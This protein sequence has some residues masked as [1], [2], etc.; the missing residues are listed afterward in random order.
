[1]AYKLKLPSDLRANITSEWN[2]TGGAISI[3]K[4]ILS[5]LF[6]IVEVKDEEKTSLALKVGML[7]GKHRSGGPSTNNVGNFMSDLEDE[8]LNAP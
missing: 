3:G 4:G 5:F 6:S 7:L 2:T 8:I 1:M